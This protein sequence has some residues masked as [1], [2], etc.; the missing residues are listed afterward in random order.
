MNVPWIRGA[1]A[2]FVFLTRIPVGGFP[3]TKDDFRWAGAYFPFVGAVLGAIAGIV[4]I[5]LLPAGAMAAAICCVALSMMLTGA[6]HEDGLA[7]TADALGGAYDREKLFVILKDS[8]VGSF[9]AAA[10]FVVLA[11][12][13]AL[14]ARL[15]S[16]ALIACVLSAC[17]ARTPP[18]WMMAALPY[19]TNDEH[20]KSRHLTR[21]GARQ[22]WVATILTSAVIAIAMTWGGLSVTRVVVMLVALAVAAAICTWRFVVRAGGITGDFLGATEQVGECVVLLALAMTAA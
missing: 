14:L 20:S 2:A 10:L 7:D 18:V 3:Y 16:E 6:F 12:R 13:V 19:V 5:A 15:E 17:I 8:R 21:G 1:R 9:G 4:M 22:A 11:L